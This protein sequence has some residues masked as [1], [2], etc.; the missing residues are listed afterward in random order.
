MARS[1]LKTPH[2]IAPTSYTGLRRLIGQ[3]NV[4][5]GWDDA[6]ERSPKKRRRRPFWPTPHVFRTAEAYAAA[7]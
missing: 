1:S 6:R 3:G 2:A 7:Q 4:A 5:D